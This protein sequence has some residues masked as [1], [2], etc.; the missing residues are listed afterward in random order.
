M[1]Q[2]RKLQNRID[3]KILLFIILGFVGVGNN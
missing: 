3:E 1:Y 2:K